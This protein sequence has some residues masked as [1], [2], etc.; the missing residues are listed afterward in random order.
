MK[1]AIDHQENFHVYTYPG[2]NVDD[3]NS[4]VAPTIKINPETIILHCGTNDLRGNDSA[5]TIA[6]TL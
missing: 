6:E 5:Q 1:E 2:A 3:M 4:H